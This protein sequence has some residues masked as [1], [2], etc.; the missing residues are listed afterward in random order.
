MRQPMMFAKDY[1][2]AAVL[3]A[4]YYLETNNHAMAMKFSE[5]A[6]AQLGVGGIKELT[7]NMAS[8]QHRAT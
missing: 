7:R 4:Q 6:Q 3:I 8:Q 2:D 1:A 5:L